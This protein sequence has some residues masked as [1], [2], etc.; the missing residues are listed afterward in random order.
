MFRIGPGFAG[1]IFQT[2]FSMTEG[3]RCLPAS[4][5]PMPPT[6]TWAAQRGGNVASHG[7]AVVIA[8]Q[9]HALLVWKEVLSPGMFLG[10]PTEADVGSVDGWPLFF[11]IVKC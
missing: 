4:S 7:G 10:T 11:L 5:L 3:R 9:M 6:I 1:G 2:V 8:F